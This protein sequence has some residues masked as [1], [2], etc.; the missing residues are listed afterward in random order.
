[1]AYESFYWRSIL[2]RDLTYLL[3]KTEMSHDEVETDLNRHFS[4]V[5]IKIMTVAY[6]IRKLADSN[7]LPDNVLK[8]NLTLTS[9][10]IRTNHKPRAFVD[11]FKE[12]DL[13]KPQ[14]KKIS[15]RELCNQI[16]HSYVL[17]A[18]G[19]SDK[20][21]TE[22]WVVSDRDSR[23]GLT[24]IPIKSFVEWGREVTNKHVTKMEA[25]FDEEKDK[26]IYKREQPSILLK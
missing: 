11:I 26:W 24:E 9:Y 17:Q 20:A 1:M 13:D 14:S 5:E 8:K 21:F 23:S 12:Y 2:K 22:F 16:I 6:I 4:F 3:K 15:L 19:D 18:D 7:K 10:P 25:R